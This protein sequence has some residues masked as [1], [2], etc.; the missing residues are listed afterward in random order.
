MNAINGRAG[1]ASM[2]QVN[3]R[4]TMETDYLYDQE[5]DSLNELFKS[6]YKQHTRFDKEPLVVKPSVSG[7]DRTVIFSVD[8]QRCEMIGNLI[9]SLTLPP[10]ESEHYYM[11]DTGFGVIDT[12]VIVNGDRE[13]ASFTGHYLMTHFLLN[14][15][16]SKR[17]GMDHMVGHCNTRY[18]LTGRSRKLYV[19]IPFMASYNDKQYYPV[20]LS[21]EFQVRVKFR[22]DIILHRNESIGVRMGVAGNGTVR[23][24]L[25]PPSNPVFDMTAELMYDGFHLSPDERLLFKTKDGRLL[26]QTVQE[27]Y[28]QFEINTTIMHFPLDL[29]GPVSYL[30]V[31]VSSVNNRF[32]FLKIDTFTLILQG[33]VIGGALTDANKFRYLHNHSIPNRYVYVIPFGISC[34]ETQPCGWMNFQNDRKNSFLVIRRKDSSLTC[35]V[36][37][38]AVS[39]DHMLFENGTIF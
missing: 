31:T 32:G 14:T 6:T 38:C 34:T 9:L 39:N 21:D 24:R 8:K 11:N 19:P 12:I 4:S 13:L 25:T 18:S 33:S 3:A 22:A 36:T 5:G 20:F 28:E 30:I 2:M 29:T 7:L 1:V 16:R 15:S 23:V 26:F 17:V 37:V 35:R 27:S 10:L